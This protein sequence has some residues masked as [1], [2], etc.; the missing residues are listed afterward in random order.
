VIAL[1]WDPDGQ[2]LYIGG[3]FVSAAQDAED[4]SSGLAVWSEATGF[5][6]F[7]GGGLTKDEYGVYGVALC[8]AF[9]PI[10]MVR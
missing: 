4:S 1:A 6:P 10:S 2:V 9:E 3:S 5:V 8:L 7:P